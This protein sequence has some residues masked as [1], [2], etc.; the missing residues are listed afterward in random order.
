[1][2]GGAFDNEDQVTVD[3]SLGSLFAG[4]QVATGTNLAPGHPGPAG[5]QGPGYSSGTYDAGTGMVTLVGVNG[6]TNVVT[7]DL[8]GMM[9]AMGNA[10]DGVRVVQAGSQTQD[11]IIQFTVQGTDIGSPVTISRG[12]QGQQGVQGE[13]RVDLFLV[14][15]TATPPP[16]PTDIIWTP[17]AGGG[18]VGGANSRGWGTM[19]MTPGANEQIYE[20]TA[21]FD[22]A[23]Q[24]QITSWSTPFLAGSQGP[25]GPMGAQ[26]FSISASS[27]SGASPGATSTVTFTSTDTTATPEVVT[28]QPGVQG[29]QGDEGNSV[30][31]VNESPGAMPGATSSFDLQIVDHN[32]VNVGSPTTITVQPGVAGTPGATSITVEDEGQAESTTVDNINFV[33]SGVTATVDPM[34]S[35]E[36]TVRVDG[37][38]APPTPQEHFTFNINP[39]QITEG[40]GSTTVTATFG[41]SGTGFTYVGYAGLAVSGPTTITLNDR[42]GTD[43]TAQFSIPN[44]T[45]GTYRVTA[46]IESNNSSGDALP[47]HAV[48]GSIHVN[49]Q[50]YGEALASPPTSEANLTGQGAYHSGVSQTFTGIVGGRLY[51]ALP[52]TTG[53]TP[54][55]RS[56][57]V[58]IDYTQITSGWTSTTHNLFDLG[59][60]AAGT[61]TVEVT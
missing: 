28:I 11:T 7:G 40:T 1:M 41:V 52:T 58:F 6:A 20:I 46:F 54:T 25:V 60:L 48:S 19:P 44:G 36:V 8:R 33:G 38:G 51:I 57:I 18:N 12:P 29:M 55:F 14:A 21:I 32:N 56:G 22:P 17:G 26:G 4:G 23:T 30:T 5:P 31:V 49:A 16:S 53:T 34:D 43:H 15:L 9:G 3:T 39:T 37:G 10:V 47:R 50:W 61:L 42:A 59:E 27:M 45:V 13:Y 24:T 2:A 35:S